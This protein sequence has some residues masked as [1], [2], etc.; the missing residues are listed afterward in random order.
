MWGFERIKDGPGKGGYKHPNFVRG[1]PSLC[2]LMKRV[3]IKGA[4]T[5]SNSNPVASVVTPQRSANKFNT[6]NE[7]EHGS[8]GTA[9]LL[10]HETSLLKFAQQVICASIPEG[11]N[12]E[13]FTPDE[14]ND[15]LITTFQTNYEAPID[16]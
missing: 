8:C 14:I 15:E 5:T 11:I 6:R 10:T 7:E 4:A 2:Y 3:K 9:W 1:V 16:W 12:T 13:T